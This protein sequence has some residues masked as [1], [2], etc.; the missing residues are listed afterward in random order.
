[1]FQVKDINI[2]DWE[3]YNHMVVKPHKDG[4]LHFYMVYNDFNTAN[5][6]T[7]HINGF[8]MMTSEVEAI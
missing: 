1:M 3:S 8:L 5:R 2:K 6:V 4:Y 7:K